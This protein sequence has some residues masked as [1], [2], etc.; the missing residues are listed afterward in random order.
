ML[1]YTLDMRN[2]KPEGPEPSE[3]D[4]VRVTVTLPRPVSE[5]ADR[6]KADP[7][8]AGNLSA[9]VRTLILDADRDHQEAPK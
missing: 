6:L 7:R 3:R 8:F 1:D 9:L 2:G 5:L 4:F